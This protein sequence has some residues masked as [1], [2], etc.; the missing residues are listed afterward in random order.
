MPFSLAMPPLSTDGFDAMISLILIREAIVTAV[1]MPSSVWSP[2]MTTETVA[3]PVST[4]PCAAAKVTT[5]S[6]PS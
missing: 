3:E 1:G 2:S 6:A 4:Y 5:T